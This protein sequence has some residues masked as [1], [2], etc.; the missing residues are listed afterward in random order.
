MLSVQDGHGR[1]WQNDETLS[2]TSLP[3][4]LFSVCL[5]TSRASKQ[6]IDR[7]DE[8]KYE[9]FPRDII[10]VRLYT[11]IFSNFISLLIDVPPYDLLH[12]L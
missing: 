7:R 2:S 11:K 6:L 4:I 9:N 8:R 3:F 5:L 10:M 12:S 1:E